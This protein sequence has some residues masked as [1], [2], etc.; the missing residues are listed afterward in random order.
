MLYEVITKSVT[1][2]NFTDI[3]GNLLSSD[4]LKGKTI[5]LNFWHPQCSPCIAELP[6]LNNLVERMKDKESYNFV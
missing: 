6:E 5:V 4:S 3:N 1:P 2:F